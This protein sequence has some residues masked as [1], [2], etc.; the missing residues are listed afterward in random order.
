M[1][2]REQARAVRQ[3][4]P[5]VS[6]RAALRAIPGALAKAPWSTGPELLERL[7]RRRMF[8][9]KL[10]EMQA[11]LR[12]LRGL[13]GRGEVTGDVRVRTSGK[14]TAMRYALVDCEIAPPPRF[15]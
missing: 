3:A 14:R 7:N 10:G 9:L 8:P 1:K 6:V 15:G 2:G 13:N 11:A 12:V 4:R 5:D